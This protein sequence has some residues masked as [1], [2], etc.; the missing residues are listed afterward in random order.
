[1]QQEVLRILKEKGILKIGSKPQFIIGQITNEAVVKTLAENITDFNEQVF[2]LISDISQLYDYVVKI[3]EIAWDIVDFTE[4][5]VSIIYPQGKNVPDFLSRKDG[6]VMI[7]MIKQGDLHYIIKNW[8]KALF[9]IALPDEY[10]VSQ[11]FPFNLQSSEN[12]KLDKGKIIHLELN[13][14]IKFF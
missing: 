1:M 7:Q 6:R 11:I 10:D 9:A 2:L 12:I 13:G 5:P 4:K 14:E 8:G 3:P